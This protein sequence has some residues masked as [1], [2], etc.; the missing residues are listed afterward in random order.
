MLTT[1]L[2]LLALTVSRPELFSTGIAF[3]FLGVLSFI[4]KEAG[5]LAIDLAD[6]YGEKGYWQPE[7]SLAALYGLVLVALAVITFLLLRPYMPI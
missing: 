3:L 2:A 4:V 7:H 6:D 5:G 1:G